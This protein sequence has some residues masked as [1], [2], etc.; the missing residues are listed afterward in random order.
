MSKSDTIYALAAI[1]FLSGCATEQEYE[2]PRLHHHS[3]I[4]SVESQANEQLDNLRNVYEE[5]YSEAER[6]G[7]V[8][9][10]INGLLLGAAIA[11][12]RGALFGAFVGAA[13]GAAYA[14]L[15]V[16]DLL[17]E[18]SEFLNR[19]QL[20]ENIPEVA[21]RATQRTEEDAGIVSRAVSHHFANV[22]LDSADPTEIANS[23]DVVTR[24][25]ELR[26]VLITEIASEGSLH[27]SEHNFV[28]LQLSRQLEAIQSMHRERQRI[29]LSISN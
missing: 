20:I 26:M 19:Q 22:E 27:E 25:A 11:G 18:H 6:R 1:I 12:E 7:F 24:V 9:G 2:E 16:D 14:T 13:A 21:T 23:V 28:D 15:V 10:G 17:L 4:S 8:S 5:L 29:L 3:D